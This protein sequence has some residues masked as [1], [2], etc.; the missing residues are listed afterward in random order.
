VRADG[1]GRGMNGWPASSAVIVRERNMASRDHEIH[2]ELLRV[3]VA[4]IAVSQ[5]CETSVLLPS[6]ETTIL[7]ASELSSI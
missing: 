2:Y 5:R 3:D 6:V 7:T 1:I 4:K